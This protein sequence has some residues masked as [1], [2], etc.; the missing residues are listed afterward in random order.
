ML[1]DPANIE[2]IWSRRKSGAN[3]AAAPIDTVEAFD[4][5]LDRSASTGS[6]YRWALTNI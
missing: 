5:D 3:V 1:N 4:A 6:W 2:K